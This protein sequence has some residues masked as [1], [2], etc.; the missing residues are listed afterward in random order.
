MANNDVAWLDP[1]ELAAWVG[2]IKVAAL[3]VGLSDGELRRRH[4]ITGR[5]YELLHHLSEDDD[6]RRVSDLALD[7]DDTSSCITHRVNRLAEAG[8]VVK[9]ADPADRRARRVSLTARGRTLLAEAAPGHATR[10]RQWVI[11]PLSR[12]DLADLTR[13]T[14]KLGPHLRAAASAG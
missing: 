14:T 6:G 1:T 9:R 10:V 12:R 4:G 13:I 5:D 8:L 11:D 3:I 2:L 7:I